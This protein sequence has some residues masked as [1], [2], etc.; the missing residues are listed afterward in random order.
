MYSVVLG[1]RVDSILRQSRAERDI[2]SLAKE[3]FAINS[4]NHASVRLMA[5]SI[6]KRYSLQRISEFPL[7]LEEGC[8]G[9][10]VVFQSS[11][12]TRLGSNNERHA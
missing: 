4:D 10:Y 8:V 9:L 2:T 1:F 11:V 12:N 7:R 3:R 5:L 6:R